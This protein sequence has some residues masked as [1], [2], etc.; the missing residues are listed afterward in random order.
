MQP[1]YLAKD[2]PSIFC[3]KTKP[4]VSFSENDEPFDIYLSDC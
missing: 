1:S 2:I 3:K 4:A